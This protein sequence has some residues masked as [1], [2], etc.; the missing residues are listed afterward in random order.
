MRGLPPT[1]R[2]D[3]PGMP[4]VREGVRPAPVDQPPGIFAD[5]FHH[6]LGAQ[7]GSREACRAPPRH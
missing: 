2:L 4:A 3:N 5:M 7:A 1:P 6:R